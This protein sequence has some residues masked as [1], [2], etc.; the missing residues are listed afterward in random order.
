MWARSRR[1]DAISAQH[2]YFRAQMRPASYKM[3][4][5]RAGSS[6]YAYERIEPEFPFQLHVH[7]EIELTLIT[8]GS[9]VRYV[10]EVAERYAAGDLVLVGGGVP[11]TWMSTCDS[12]SGG[13]VTQFG[14]PVVELIQS[15]EELAGFRRTLAAAPATVFEDGLSIIHQ[16]R[17]IIRASPVA[18]LARLIALFGTLAAL[19]KRTLRAGRTS[20]EGSRVMDDVCLFVQECYARPIRRSEAA[21]VAHMGDSA[22]SRY[23][24]R[25][26]GR[27][28]SRYVNEVRSP[29]PASQLDETDTPIAGIAHEVGFRNLSNFNRQFAT[30]MATTPRAYR[31]RMRT[32]AVRPSST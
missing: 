15:A 32:L 4:P 27:S 30:L 14:H 23:F 17:G 7:P 18:R 13:I 3:V 1:V 31:T 29:R 8:L 25:A 10:G 22:F 2:W 9:G 5:R 11:H 24:A 6:I 12:P 19:E 26:T 16:L 20:G 28:F 21:R